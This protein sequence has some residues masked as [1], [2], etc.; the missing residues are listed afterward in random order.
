MKLAPKLVALFLLFLIISLASL[1]FL[2]YDNGRQSIEQDTLDR[3]ATVTIL[4]EAEFTRWLRGNQQNLRTMAG[5][6]S[7][8]EYAAVLA[9]LEPSDPTYQAAQSSLLNEHL[10]L[11]LE[12]ETSFLHLSILRSGDGMILISSDEEL[13]GKYRESEPFF[14]EGK[15]H[16]YVQNPAYSVSQG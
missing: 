9:A 8:G 5:R 13:E 12:E 15:Q 7:V 10:A 1:G 6:P 3:L 14:L 11:T 16:T 4:K 2:A